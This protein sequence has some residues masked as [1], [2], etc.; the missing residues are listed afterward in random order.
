MLLFGNPVFDG[1][2]SRILLCFSID[3]NLNEAKSYFHNGRGPSLS[4]WTWHA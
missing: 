2:K 3:T 1:Q 4:C